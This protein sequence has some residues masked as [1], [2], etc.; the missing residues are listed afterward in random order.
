MKYYSLPTETS[1]LK[2]LEI[3]KAPQ[4]KRKLTEKDANF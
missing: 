1:D 3:E 2:G 4:Q